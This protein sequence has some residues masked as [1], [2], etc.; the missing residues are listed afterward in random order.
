M[1]AA[2]STG[3]FLIARDNRH[4]LK[5]LH[6]VAYSQKKSIP[7][8]TGHSVCPLCYRRTIFYA[9]FKNY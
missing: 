9:R 5:N 4:L 6:I 2:V 3:R 1:T 8:E 7:L